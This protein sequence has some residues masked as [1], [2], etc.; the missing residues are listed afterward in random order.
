MGCLV[1]VVKFFAIVMLILAAPPVLW[2]AYVY[3]NFYVR[4]GEPMTVA[5][6]QR[7]APGLTF[8]DFWASRERQ[9]AEDSE[10][11]ESVGSDIRCRISLERAFLVRHAV[12]S[13]M[14]AAHFY[15]RQDEDARMQ[16]YAESIKMDQPAY[17]WP[18]YEQIYGE[19][20]MDAAWTMFEAYAWRFYAN[21]TGRPN[22]D[23]HRICA[24]SFP[25]PADVSA[26]HDDAAGALP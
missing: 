20:L 10:K 19:S 6:A 17:P 12:R 24:T 25:T 15:S 7:R 21:H 9:W 14:D 1:K 22:R 26:N 11:L 4:S 2:G 16:L 5:E 18:T 3:A 23:F 13:M 8:R